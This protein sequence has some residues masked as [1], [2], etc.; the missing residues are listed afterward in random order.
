MLYGNL[1][2]QLYINE[3][4]WL[5]GSDTTVMGIWQTTALFV[6]TLQILSLVKFFL[7]NFLVE[8]R[9]VCVWRIT[10]KLDRI[11]VFLKD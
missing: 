10:F 3:Y 8:E 6:T 2:G 9:N 5:S 11:S 1:P 4:V 7:F